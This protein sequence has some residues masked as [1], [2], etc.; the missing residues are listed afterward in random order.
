[1]PV[2]KHFLKTVA[3]GDVVV[4]KMLPKDLP[5]DPDKEWHGK[6]LRVHLDEPRLI[7]C[8]Y[9]ESLDFEESGLTEIVYLSQVVRKG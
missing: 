5:V 9:V 3:I 4:Y 7:D 1:M 2:D 8:L 6:I